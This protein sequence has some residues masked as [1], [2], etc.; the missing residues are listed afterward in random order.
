MSKK[1]IF[2][3]ALRSQITSA[4]IIKNPPVALIYMEDLPEVFHE[5]EDV[6]S[7]YVSKSPPYTGHLCVLPKGF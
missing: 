7:S 6:C 4:V 1:F 5:K 3:E 2:L